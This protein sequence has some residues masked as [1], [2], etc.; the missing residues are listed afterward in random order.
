M[1]SFSAERQ[2]ERLSTRRT[3]H[4]DDTQ[5]ARG[6][7]S[8][9]QPSVDSIRQ[10]NANSQVKS[11]DKVQNSMRDSV[12][13][14]LTEAQQ[15]YFKDSKVRDAPAAGVRGRRTGTGPHQCRTARMTGSIG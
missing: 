12:G 15:E 5:S 6:G 2:N 11:N 8:N 13:R 10:S 3:L 14:E 4:A 9:A 7:E 1:Y